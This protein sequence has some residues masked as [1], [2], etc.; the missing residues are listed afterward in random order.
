MMTSLAVM[1]S[2]SSSV[3]TRQPATNFS[4][5]LNEVAVA[6]PFFSSSLRWSF[7]PPGSAGVFHTTLRLAV[8]PLLP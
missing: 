7:Q 5:L 2:N 3:P 4:L 1:V 6:A 8:V